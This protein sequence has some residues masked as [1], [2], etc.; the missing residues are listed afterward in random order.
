MRLVFVL[1]V[2]LS[3]PLRTADAQSDSTRSSTLAT[4][5]G[6]VTDSAGLPLANATVTIDALRL[7]ARAGD[8]GEYRL[9]AIPLGTHLVTARAVGYE[10]ATLTIDF[11]AVAERT[12]T[13]AMRLT[14]TI[15]DSVEVKATRTDPRMA[16]FEENR[17]LGL[18][19][20][21]TSDQLRKQEGQRLSSIVAMIPGLGLVNGRAN[22]A[23]I[24]SKRKV[25]SGG[26]RCRPWDEGRGSLPPRGGSIF[27]PSRAE[28]SQGITCACYAQVYM[29]GQLMNPGMPAD[30]FDVNSIPTHQIEAIEYYSGPSQTPSK[31]S[32]LNS[33]CGVYVMHT[34]RPEGD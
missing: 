33:P 10:P 9:T 2:L 25:G 8:R 27:I 29:D 13:F 17:K 1:S 19:H 28:M 26:G 31:Y 34:R 18:G 4:L 24:L 6:L 3:L 20:F 15:L 11:P 7:T 22:Q 14:R 23:W 5:S 21:I 12:R 16:E 30:P 32:R